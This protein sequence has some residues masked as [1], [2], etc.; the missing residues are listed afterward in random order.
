[1]DED[2][3]EPANTMPRDDADPNALPLDE[4]R[5]RILAALV[6]IDEHEQLSLLQANGRIA[7]RR[8]VAPGD[9]P[10]FRAS[11]MDGFAYRHADPGTRR[12]IVA[13]SL[14]GHPGPDALAEGGCQRITT[15][16]RVPDEADT[17]VQQEDVA[18]H[19]DT[20]VIKEVPVPGLNVRAAGSAGLVGDVLVEPGDRLG[21]ATL[22]VMAAHGVDRVHATRRLRVGLLST[23]DELRDPCEPLGPGQIHDANR[24]LLAAL[25]SGPLIELVDMGIVIDSPSELAR[26][27]ARRTDIDLLI[28]SGGVSVG[29]ADHVREVLGAD[30]EVNL[31]KIAMKPGRPLAFGHL[32]DGRVWFGLPGNPV[33]AAVTSLFLVLPALRV[34]AGG[35]AGDLPPARSAVLEQDVSKRPGR[36]EFQRGRI[37]RDDNAGLYVTSV[38]AQDSHVLRSLRLGDCLIAL[39]ASSAGA[40]AGDTVSIWRYEDF[41]SSPF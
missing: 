28:T 29:D 36:V 26:R 8:I 5:R 21:S 6:P 20:I 22:A 39:P 17:V 25:L 18:L 41:G 27:I 19:D 31:W 16:A 10:P 15:G 32:H 13:R 38:G 11:A 4:A 7:A 35:A 14:A 37:R 1:M 40:K 12:R 9:V 24:I 34:M 2:S 3:N 30:G 23:G 33:S